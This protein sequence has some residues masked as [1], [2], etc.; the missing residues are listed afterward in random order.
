MSRRPATAKHTPAPVIGY[1]VNA[2]SEDDKETQLDEVGPMLVVLRQMAEQLPLTQ[3][4]WEQNGLD[5]ESYRA[6]LMTSCILDSVK[7]TRL[8]KKTLN[9]ALSATLTYDP[10]PSPET[11][12][13]FSNVEAR[14]NWYAPTVM[15]PHKQAPVVFIGSLVCVNHN[16]DT[17]ATGTQELPHLSSLLDHNHA[18]QTVDATLTNN[19]DSYL[20]SLTHVAVCSDTDINTLQ[21]LTQYLQE[22][23]TNLAQAA[24]LP[25]NESLIRKSFYHTPANWKILHASYLPASITSKLDTQ[26][27]NYTVPMPNLHIPETPNETP[28]TFLDWLR[29]AAETHVPESNGFLYQFNAAELDNED[30]NLFFTTDL[31]AQTNSTPVYPPGKKKS[32]KPLPDH[33]IYRDFFLQNLCNQPDLNVPHD[34]RVDPDR[35]MRLIGQPQPRNRATHCPRL[36]GYDWEGTH[37]RLTRHELADFTF[38][39]YQREGMDDEWVTPVLQHQ[40]N[41]LLDFVWLY[42]DARNGRLRARADGR[43]TY[44][45]K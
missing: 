4:I 21:K 41:L 16:Y 42:N 36:R 14:T 18:E 8:I 20:F 25:A 44:V 43:A 19:P 24:P 27:T 45:P 26:G 3:S 2:I 40:Q 23:E 38:I 15:V 6:Y 34:P 39:N 29:D 9:C 37:Q 5:V 33:L 13:N 7:Q 32:G 35:F 11:P 28:T 22:A 12:P 17:T 31:T 1:A 10:A 30:T